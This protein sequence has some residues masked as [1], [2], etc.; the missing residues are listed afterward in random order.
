M[1]YKVVNGD[2]LLTDKELLELQLI[3][4]NAP[5]D[6]NTKDRVMKNLNIIYN[7]T[8]LSV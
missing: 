8:Y 7:Q 2:E 6:G 1:I 3:T 5:A 4:N